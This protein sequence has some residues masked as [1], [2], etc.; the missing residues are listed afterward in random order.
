MEGT[1][2]CSIVEWL[3]FCWRLSRRLRLT[4]WSPIGAVKCGGRN[5]SA[6]EFRTRIDGAGGDREGYG[7]GTP[8]IISWS[9]N[10]V[11]RRTVETVLWSGEE[12]ARLT[13][14]AVKGS[15][16]LMIFVSWSRGPDEADSKSGTRTESLVHA[17]RSV[18]AG[19][20][21]KCIIGAA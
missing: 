4:Q 2:Q 10:T 1:K 5:H 8:D 12:A 13:L 11:H 9:V 19:K 16:A 18:R 15:P 20:P 21:G 6:I 17:N 7:M 3:P 14:T